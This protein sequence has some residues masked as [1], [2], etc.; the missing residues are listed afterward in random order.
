M[1]LEEFKIFIENQKIEVIPGPEP[2]HH[3]EDES[4][5]ILDLGWAISDR[6]V[7]IEEKL[8]RIISHPSFR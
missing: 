4:R 5:T 1:T 6:L 7:Q 2:K 8:D 3:F